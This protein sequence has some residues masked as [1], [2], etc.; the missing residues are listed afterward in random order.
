MFRCGNACVVPGDDHI[1]VQ[2]CKLVGELRKPLRPP[3][4]EP[5]LIEHVRALYISE[6]SQTFFKRCDEMRRPFSRRHCEGTDPIY[7][8][9]PLR[10]GGERRGEKPPATVPRNAL[11]EITG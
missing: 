6:F 7:L 10:L 5:V 4:G 3:L 2:Y 1:D 11:L 9:R 8:P